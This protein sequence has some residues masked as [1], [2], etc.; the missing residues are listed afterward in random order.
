MM[1]G[2]IERGYSLAGVWFGVFL[3]DGYFL[4]NVTKTFYRSF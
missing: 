2:S 3:F 4:P 1:R